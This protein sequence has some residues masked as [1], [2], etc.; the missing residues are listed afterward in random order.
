MFV[1]T[2]CGVFAY[3]PLLKNAFSSIQAA[4]AGRDRLFGHLRSLTEGV[5]EVKMSSARQAQ[6]I[7]QEIGGAARYLRKVNLTATYEYMIADGWSQAMF[8][9]IMGMLLFALPALKNI[10]SST[11]I[12][13]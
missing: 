11:R 10:T 6:M 13:L 2:V 1:A 12:T 8:Y 9:L 7:E 5:K 4:R 3:R